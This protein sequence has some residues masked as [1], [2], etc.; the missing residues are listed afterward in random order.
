MAM[1]EISGYG[2]Q[3]WK[4]ESSIFPLSVSLFIEVKLQI[5]VQYKPEFKALLGN[6]YSNGLICNLTHLAN[7]Q[8]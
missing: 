6:Q 1:A 2:C 3:S 7:I 8:H 4:T 5:P